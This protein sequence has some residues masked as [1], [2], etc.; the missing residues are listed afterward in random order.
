[1]SSAPYEE[2]CQD[3]TDM[4][5]TEEGVEAQKVPAQTINN[6]SSAN[7]YDIKSKPPPTNFENLD[8]VQIKEMKALKNVGRDWPDDIES[9]SL[10]HLNAEKENN[11]NIKYV[12]SDDLDKNNQNIENVKKNEGTVQEKS[13]G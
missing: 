7:A 12:T 10:T 11:N 6:D 13:A 1:M 2:K 3:A 8:V 9:E 5:N 4:E